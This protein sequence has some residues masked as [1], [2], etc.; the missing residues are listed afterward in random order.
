MKNG[1]PGIFVDTN[2]FVY[3]FD[4]SNER[5]RRLARALLASDDS[6]FVISTQVI[7]EFANVALKKL[8]LDAT[9]T[10]LIVDKLRELETVP[11]DAALIKTAVEIHAMHRLSF[12]DSLII[13]A[14]EHAGC[15]TMYSE[16]LNDG[17]RIRG[18]AISNPF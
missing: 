15:S 12:Y 11:V 14:A 10:N 13:A 8:G 3:A 1:K 6:R 9:Q 5:K 4:K 18:V 16:D 7:G 17:Q 2:V